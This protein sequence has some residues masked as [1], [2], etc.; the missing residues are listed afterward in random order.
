ML[1]QKRFCQDIREK[2]LHHME[3]IAWGSCV[4]SLSFRFFEIWV[5]KALSSL[6]WPELTLL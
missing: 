3:V 6:L 5:D 2:L 1:K 4:V